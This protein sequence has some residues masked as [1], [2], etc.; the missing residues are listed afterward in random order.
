LYKPKYNETAIAPP[1]A[2]TTRWWFCV[3]WRSWG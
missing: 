1:G 3:V 2:P